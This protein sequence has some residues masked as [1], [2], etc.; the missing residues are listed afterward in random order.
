MVTSSI[1]KFLAAF[2]LIIVGVIFINII[3]AETNGST[4]PTYVTGEALSIASARLVGNQINQSVTFTLTNAGLV[5]AGGWVTDSVVI[6][7]AT[8]QTLVGNYTVNYVTDR[9]T[10]ANNTYMV[11]GGGLNNNTLVA[12]QYYSGDYI[13][14]DFGRS[15]LDLVAGFLA[16]ALLGVGIALFYGI[17]KENK[18][19]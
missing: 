3:A 1:P 4:E 7:N 15:I 16:I 2:I 9:I 5:D 19:V 12:Y 18:I 13:N 10:F 17:A 8:G 14:S 6:T 11:S